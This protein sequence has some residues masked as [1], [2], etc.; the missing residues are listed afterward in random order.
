[1]GPESL[2]FPLLIK[3]DDDYIF[4]IISSPFPKSCYKKVSRTKSV[5]SE[6]SSKSSS[7]N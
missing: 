6:S 5:Y 3:R 4:I 7:L 1:M 2:I